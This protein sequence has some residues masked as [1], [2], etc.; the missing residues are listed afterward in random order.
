MAMGFV[1]L[2]V[3]GDRNNSDGM[4]GENT[5]KIGS[6]SANADNSFKKFDCENKNGLWLE[7]DTG[8]GRIRME[9][10]NNP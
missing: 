3:T 1:H 9:R 2:K 6:E 10:L 8:S 5:Q 7:K 4:T